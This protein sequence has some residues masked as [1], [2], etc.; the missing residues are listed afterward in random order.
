M[1]NAAALSSFSAFLDQR[2]KEQRSNA[3]QGAN[4][5][6]H[7]AV[8]ANDACFPAHSAS[9]PGANV[10]EADGQGNCYY[11]QWLVCHVSHFL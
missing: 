2:I 6:A 1:A 11:Y 10:L 9:Y 5:A 8:S 7:C 4:Q 3:T